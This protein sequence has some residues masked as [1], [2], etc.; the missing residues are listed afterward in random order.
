MN[1]LLDEI[2][3]FLEQG[4]R[5]GAWT[6]LGG[7]GD[8]TNAEQQASSLLQRLV[9]ERT[10]ADTE[11]EKVVMRFRNFYRC[12]KCGHEWDDCWDSMCNDECPECGIK[13]ITPFNSEELYIA[14]PKCGGVEFYASQ[15]C[16]GNIAVMAYINPDGTTMFL[17]N[18]C[19]D[20]SILTDG[21]D[22]DDP[23]GPFTCAKC[24]YEM[25]AKDLP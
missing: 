16:R 19:D 24:E 5:S 6:E 15:S 7:V 2:Q 22:F 11:S 23:E 12:P 21:L 8:N 20:D 17:R 1:K 4:V 13:D 3:E 10:P 25:T 9:A 14:C 18:T